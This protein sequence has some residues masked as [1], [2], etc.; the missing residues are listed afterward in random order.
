VPRRVLLVLPLLALSAC[1]GAQ[2]G[3][4]ESAADRFYA[5]LDSDDGADAC[6]LLSA[7]TRDQLEQ[8]AGKACAQAVVEEGL[9]VPT[10]AREVETFG[11][12]AQV[13]WDGETTFLSRYGDRWLV[14]AAGCLPVPGDRYDCALQGG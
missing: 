8:S 14:V 4:V 13:R 9:T 5:A 7:R 6:A 2:D 3:S 11:T 1:G 10:A 12:A